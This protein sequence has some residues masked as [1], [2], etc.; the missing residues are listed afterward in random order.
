MERKETN[1]K[2]KA[3]RAQLEDAAAQVGEIVNAAPY[4][5]GSRVSYVI[6]RI[7]QAVEDINAC[8][9]YPPVSWEVT[10]DETTVTVTDEFTRL[11]FRFEKG[12][13]LALYRFAVLH[14]RGALSTAEGMET[15]DRVREEFLK[16]ART[17]YRDQFQ[18]MPAPRSR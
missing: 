15:L 14:P 10:E 13:R 1:E 6:D 5:Y 17:N 12:D 11:G 7:T 4:R 16:Y 18:E 8:L 2:L 3:V 9:E